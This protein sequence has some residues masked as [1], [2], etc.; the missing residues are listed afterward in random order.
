MALPSMASATIVWFRRMTTLRIVV[1]KARGLL[2]PAWV[3]KRPILYGIV[4]LVLWTGAV[5]AGYGWYETVVAGWE[6]RVLEQAGTSLSQKNGPAEILLGLEPDLKSFAAL[7]PFFDEETRER[8]RMAIQAAKEPKPFFLEAISRDLDGS[9]QTMA[10]FPAEPPF[11]PGKELPLPTPEGIESAFLRFSRPLSVSSTVPIVH[12]GQRVGRISGLFPLTG[13]FGEHPAGKLTPLLL[14]WALLGAPVSIFL[15]CLLGTGL[16]SLAASIGT[17]AKKGIREARRSKSPANVGPEEGQWGP[18]RLIRRLGRGGMA[19]L[20]LAENVRDSF[21]KRLALKR[22]HPHLIDDREFA[23]RFRQEARLAAMLEHPNI[24][25][26]WDFQELEKGA[27]I[28]M[29]YV[30]GLNLADI[31]KRFGKPHPVEQAVFFLLQIGSGLHY[32]HAKKDEETGRPLWI[33]HRDVSPQ[34]IMVSMEGEVKISDFGIARIGPDAGL[35]QPGAFMGKFQYAAP[36]QLRGERH[37]VDHRSDIYSLGVIGYELL[38]GRPLSNCKTMEE[39]YRFMETTTIPPV[40]DGFPDTP[41]E[42]EAI[43][44]KALEKESHRRFQSA[45][46]MV[47]A[48]EDLRRGFSHLYGRTDLARFMGNLMESQIQ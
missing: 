3:R 15:L 39:A 1:R 40:R 45:G 37:A 13:N 26:T 4:F 27:I 24:V 47:E 48:L 29:E 30:R 10:R 20:Y 14:A 12:D 31:Q 11:L 44:M 33:V 42:L 21:R 2:T 9:T 41:E 16:V 28:V 36:E 46:E 32:S 34:N 8:L 19:E 22:I 18:Y 43:V 38:T 23:R 17:W 5:L 35:T 6:K 7:A 25:R